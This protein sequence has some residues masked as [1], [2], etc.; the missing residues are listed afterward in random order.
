MS[1]RYSESS[2]FRQSATADP[3]PLLPEAPN[4]ADPENNIN[5]SSCLLPLHQRH[6]LPLPSDPAHRVSFVCTAHPCSTPPPPTMWLINWCKCRHIP[7]GPTLRTQHHRRSG[8]P[9]SLE[10]SYP[11]LRDQADA[12]SSQG[13]S[14]A[15]AGIH[16]T[17]SVLLPAEANET[18]AQD[19]G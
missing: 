7:N 8:L 19:R 4:L 5:L 16:P 17:P 3:D 6:R 11:E 1:R 14:P 13:G 9:D 10:R 15:L 2:K 12:P 18:F